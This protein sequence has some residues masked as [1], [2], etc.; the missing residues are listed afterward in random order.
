M[1]LRRN[2]LRSLEAS[3]VSVLLIQSIRYLY[4]ALFADLSSADL[5]RRLADRSALV[6]LP[7]YVDPTEARAEVLAVI[8]VCLAPLLGLLLT[9]TR[10]S[11][12]L[13]VL[14]VV[15][16]RYFTLDATNT[17]VLAAAVVVGAALLY[18][19][20]LIVRRPNY[21]PAFIA[22]G[23][24]GDQFIRALHHTSDP[25][26]DPA[27]RLTL[28]PLE[29]PLATFFLGL[30]VFTF[31]LTTLTTFIEREEE[32]MAAPQKP[33]R[34][35]LGLWSALAL[36]GI[37]F[38]EFT[39]LGLPHAAARWTGVDYSLMLPLMLLATAL[40]LVPE[41][42]AQ[43]ANFVSIFDGLYRG[44]LW[45]LMLGLFIVISRRFDGLAAGAVLA[46][47]QFFT[48]LTLWW[49]VK[50]PEKAPRL[51]PTPLL[52][53][54][55]VVI[56]LGLSVG[57]YF[58]YDYAFVRPFAVPFGFLDTI[59]GGMR[60]MGLPL[61]LAA[62]ILSCMPMILER[63]II[64]WRPGKLSET[65]LTL[66]LVVGIVA[67]AS[68]QALAAPVRRPLNPDCLRVATF[69]IHSGYT[70]LFAPNLELVAD[71]IERSG[72][73][74]V[75]L[76]EV[77]V[78]ILRSGST[79]QALWLAQRLNM[80]ATFYPQNEELQGLTIL[81]RLDVLKA[82]GSPLSSQTSQGVVQYVQYALDEAGALHLYNVWLS[83][84]T[85]GING[86]A[87][88]QEAQD[89]TRQVEELE[90]LIAA[91]HFS[92]ENAGQDRVVLGGTFNHGEDSPLY[93]AWAQ[94]I[95][96]DPFNS[97]FREDRYT[98]T[99]VDGQPLRLDY[100]WLL[101]LLPSGVNIYHSSQA[102][103]HYLAFAAVGRQV[104]LRCE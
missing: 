103:D 22:T 51:N 6:N 71:T 90:R 45:A 3:I 41:V 98:L 23:L 30:T 52:I 53:L 1:Q 80:N 82:T 34:G 26:F 13:T 83:L 86:E 99:T 102:S 91:N 43:A 101:N 44:W 57:D 87:L 62:V 75:L 8:L 10:W 4:A 20:I 78:G 76:Q 66:G 67:Y 9:R 63:Q 77:E 55:S 48:I 17:S 46:V 7:G 65:V 94:T 50:Q 15:M 97:L 14:T 19:T 58:T 49:L 79:D 89:Q 61:A 93:Q 64:P 12:P 11:F 28:G 56:F 84:P 81:S 35:V 59:L 88:P 68:S 37:L 70:Q 24:V 73:D 38:L 36:G 100:L 85:R 33:A 96:E 74:V 39:V 31:L 5:T 47:A 40:P 2:L 32:R 104:G 16:A 25:T 27:Y 95:F 54:L 60:D 18:L 92:A 42:R 29:L 21:F 69:N 72:A